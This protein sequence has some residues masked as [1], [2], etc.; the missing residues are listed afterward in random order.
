MIIKMAK[1]FVSSRE[2]ALN[3]IAENEYDLDEN[4]KEL[5]C[6]HQQIEHIVDGVLICLLYVIIWSPFF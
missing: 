4:G 3:I 1:T 5:N 6:S 2:I